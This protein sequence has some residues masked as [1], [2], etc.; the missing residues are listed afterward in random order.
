MLGDGV[1]FHFRDPGDAVA[2]SLELVRQVRTVDLPPAHIGVNAGTMIYDEGDHFGRTVSLASRIAG[3]AGADQVFV[4]EE[5]ARIVEPRAFEFAD[6]GE[7]TL[8]GFSEPVGIYEARWREQ[9]WITTTTD[10]TTI[11]STPVT[12]PE[13]TDPMRV[14]RRRA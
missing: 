10:T 7:F 4:G 12:D 1:H 13:I 11:R 5:V 2:A 9:R 8:K 6:A 3:Q 14:T